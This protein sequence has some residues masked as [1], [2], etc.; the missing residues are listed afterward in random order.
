MTRVQLTSGERM[1]YP[2]AG[3]TKADVFAY[4]DL[5]G[6]LLLPFL[7]ERALTVERFPKGIR[8]DGFMQ[9]NIPQHAPTDLVGRYQVPREEGGTTTYPVVNSEDGVLFFANLG[10][11]TFHVPPC[12]VKDIRHPDWVIWDL[13][14]PAGA[15]GPVREAAYVLQSVLEA[16]SLPSVIMTSG[17]K[18][19]HLRIPLR[20]KVTADKV[21]HMARSVAALATAAYPGLLTLAFRKSE[22]GERVF[23]DWLRNMPLS[24][25][26]APW[27]LRPSPEAP[28]ATPITWKEV[29][30]IGP[31]DVRLGDVDD[32]L[33]LDPWQGVS[34]V[35]LTVAV[36]DVA[37]AIDDAEITLEPFDR[38]RS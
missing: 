1:I 17:S 16:F 10:A 23:V 36:N 11:I 37:A 30:Q 25:S 7:R 12:R 13:D 28:V 22:R 26:V 6:P 21:S 14:P 3:V 33:R 35:D 8:D 24:T 29:D 18:G 34:P 38:F 15:T 27:S 9:K 31:A 5:V 20:P 2:E 4:Y 19:Y 32:R